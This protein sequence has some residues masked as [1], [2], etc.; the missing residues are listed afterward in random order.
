MAGP[1]S[2]SAEGPTYAPP[3]LPAGWIAQWDGASRKYYYVQLSTGVSQWEVPTE[4]VQTGNTPAPR[5]E[6][7]YGSPHHGVGGAPGQGTPGPQSEVITHPDGSQTVR[8][9]DG[10]M[11]PIMPD[12]TR[13]GSTGPNGERGLGVSL[14]MCYPLLQQQERERLCANQC[15]GIQSMA[16]NAL[17]GSK[18]S[19]NSSGHGGHSGSGSSPLSGLANQF[20]GGG[21]SGGHGSSSGGGKNS[22]GKLV[23]QLASNFLSS[24]SSKPSQQQQNYHGGSPSGEQSHHQGGLAGAVMGGV[25]NMFGNKPGHGSSVSIS[26]R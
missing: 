23:G 17:L 16:L 26:V 25:A 5:A 13:A 20:L 14:H 24:S 7:P 10:T 12:G 9:A 1:T 2:P 4:P 21:S 22:A 6:H 15:G 19:G 8:H 18:N 3:S 11:E